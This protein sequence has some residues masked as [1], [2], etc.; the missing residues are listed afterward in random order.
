MLTFRTRRSLALPFLLLGLSAPTIEARENINLNREWKFHLGDEAGAASVTHDVGGWSDIHLPHSFSLPYFMA[1]TFYTGYGWYRKTIDVPAEWAGRRVAV[2]FEAAFQDAEIYLNGALVGRHRG[3]YVGF[4]FDLTDSLR[5]GGNVLAVR[6]NNLWRPDLAPRAGDHTFG[7]GLYRDVRLVVTDPLHVTWAGTFVTTPTLAAKAGAESTVRIRTELRN[8]SG[9]DQPAIVRTDILDPSGAKVA[10]VSTRLTVAAG[11]TVVCDQT[12]EPVVGPHLWAP[13]HPHLY[14]AKTTVFED[15]A[16][17]ARDK[18][19]DSYETTFGFRWTEWTADRGFFLNGKHVWLR[20]ANVHQDHAGWGDAVTNAAHERDVRMVKEAGFNFIRGSHYPKD[21]AFA[22][23]C[24]RL[25]VLWMSENTFW[26]IGGRH[27]DGGWGASAYPVTS[28]HEARFDESV[29]HSLRSM[30]RVHRNS[31]SIM[32]WSMSN[33]AFFSDV[34]MA[35]VRAL[36]EKSVALSRELDPTRPAGVGGAQRPL[37]SERIDRIGDFAAYNGD[38]ATQPAFQKPGVPSLVSEYGS[39]TVDR[40]GKFA[41]GWGDLNSQLTNGRPTRFPWRAGEAVWC[42]YDHGSHAGLNLARMGIVDYFRVPKQAYHWYRENYAGVPAPAAPSNNPPAKISLSADKSLLAAPDGTDDAQLSITLVDAAG[43]PVNATVP[44]TLS[45]VSGPGEFPT[46]RTITFSPAGHGDASDIAIRDGQAA[47]AFRSYHAG[48]TV[49]RASSPGLPD[50]A[51]TLVTGGAPLFVQGVTP[52]SPDRPYARYVARPSGS[53][54]DGP[55]AE[56]DASL[57][58]ASRS[59][60]PA[61]DVL[62]LNRPTKAGA[63]AAGSASGLANDGDISTVW[64]APDA[65]ERHTWEVFLEVAYDVERITLVFPE[66]ANHRY[67]IEVAGGDMNWRQVIDQSSTA[68]TDLRRVA[69]GEFGRDIAHIRVRFV[70]GPGSPVPALAEVRVAGPSSGPA[71]PGGR[72]AGTVI[73]TAGSWGSDPALTR[74]AVFDGDTAT[75]FDAPTTSGAWVGLDF[76]A[77]HATRLTGVAYAPRFAAGN[78][79]F[80]GR[81]VGARIQGA[82]RADFQDAVDLLTITSAPG[83]GQLTVAP[84]THPGAFRYVRYLSPAEG[85][86]NLSEL[87]FLGDSSARPPGKLSGAVIG[88]FGSWGGDPAVTRAAVFDGDLRTFFDAPQTSGA[89]VGI[90]LG[91]AG[92]A[93]VTGVAY[94]PRFRADNNTF[95]RRMV[96]GVFEGANRPDFSDAVPFFT[97]T[98]VPPPGVLTRR[99]F[100]AVGPFRYLRYRSPA[101]GSCNLSELAFFGRSGFAR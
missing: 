25:G 11:A 97:V 19:V 8:A 57:V 52:L 15:R 33:E 74:E 75:Y 67:F 46:G 44:V 56:T 4:T 28:E 42:M 29:L 99:E 70:T 18:E 40:P 88:T 48:T 41:P 77:D 78:H 66:P 14:T 26:G 36:L 7:G 95:P 32:A 30:I 16:L 47:I 17:L 34:P 6:L 73:G 1:P 82:N 39:V 76:G 31:P 62:A 61:G 12:T 81:M 90:D 54:P 20:G 72:P 59:P 84:I 86:C 96:G 35:K 53:V 51:L 24:D 87:A 9:V 68:S 37:N 80:P 89:W 13:E 2:E 91:E 100:P 69:T 63:S 38:G 21:P 71:L 45:I 50:A 98:D 58:S 83:P 64:R 10:G 49:L 65:G 85:S 94:A 3:G 5:P 79:T 22:E 92:P 93:R 101:E 43:R 55:D 60:A 27:S 23:A